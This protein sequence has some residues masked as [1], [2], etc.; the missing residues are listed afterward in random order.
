MLIKEDILKLNIRRNIFIYIEKNPGLSLRKLSR[1]LKIPKSTL[2]YHL[3]FLNKFGIIKKEKEKGFDLY[4]IK[5]KVGNKDKE[6][7]SLLRKKNFLRIYI[8]LIFSGSFS[9]KDLCRDLDLNPATVSI[10]IKKFLE[11]GII[12]E[13]PNINGKIYPYKKPTQSHI[14]IKRKPVKSEKFYRQMNPEYIKKIYTVLITHKSSLPDE[15]LIECFIIYLNEIKI[16]KKVLRENGLK[17]PEKYP[18]FNKMMFLASDYV[19]DYIRPPF[20]Y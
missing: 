2:T 19:M 16:E 15:N 17:V 14:Y 9:H 4:F 5:N 7:I 13:V 8:Y 3:F 20:V 10:N 11:L 12:E 18:N 1:R 6:I